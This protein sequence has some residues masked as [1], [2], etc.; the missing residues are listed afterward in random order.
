MIK[1][2]LILFKTYNMYLLVGKSIFQNGHFLPKCHISNGTQPPATS[3]LGAHPNPT[4]VAMSA[5][6]NVKI[7]PLVAPPRQQWHPK[8]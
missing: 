6:T 5:S 8:N 1:D 3:I 2:L 4:L 7:A